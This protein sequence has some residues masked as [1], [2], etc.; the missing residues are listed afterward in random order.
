MVC[1]AFRNRQRNCLWH[2]YG[3]YLILGLGAIA[4]CVLIHISETSLPQT[5]AFEEIANASIDGHGTSK[6]MT[7][8]D[9]EHTKE[10][11]NYSDS[12]ITKFKTI[13]YKQSGG[14]AG[15]N[16]E[17]KV[18]A[19]SLTDKQ[20]LEIQDILNEIRFFQSDPSS[21]RGRRPNQCRLL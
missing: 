6:D 8:L 9:F 4:T 21:S 7:G 2:N 12:N 18:E 15:S 1:G 13:Y 19:R 5:M 17:I 14:F 11:E 16:V 10:L 20:A 3:M